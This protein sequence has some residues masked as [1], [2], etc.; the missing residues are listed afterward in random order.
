MTDLFFESN[1]LS[2]SGDGTSP[3]PAYSHT[4]KTS[5]ARSQALLATLALAVPLSSSSTRA[6]EK[7]VSMFP[8]SST[9]HAF[10]PD[11]RVAKRS[12]APRPLP[13]TAEQLA[14]VQTFFSL[15]KTQL[16]SVCGVQRQTVYDWYARSFEAAGDNARRL[17]KIFKIVQR[18]QTAEPSPLSARLLKR[19]LE[20][21]A[22]LLVMLSAP[23]LHA[24]EIA[25]V[26]TQLQAANET[27]RSRGAAGIRARLGW[28]A[29][30]QEAGQKN[31]EA[32]LEDFV[33]G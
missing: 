2:T 9:V 14:L 5:S 1:E 29:R 22:S 24:D 17:A 19:P 3:Q 4:L 13:A 7:W 32:N 15:S 21:G 16:A 11:V 31:L 23:D 28:P 18:L 6:E 12:N 25:S 30:S 8:Q 27:M 20:S 33:D 10:L 26:V